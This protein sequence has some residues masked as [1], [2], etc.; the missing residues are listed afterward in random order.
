M[1]RGYKI[2]LR[3]GLQMVF[4]QPEPLMRLRSDELMDPLI[5]Y[6]PSFRSNSPKSGKGQKFILPKLKP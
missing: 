4:G 3:N 6:I 2:L 5:Y 1:P